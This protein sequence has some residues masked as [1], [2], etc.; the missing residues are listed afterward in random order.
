MLDYEVI[1]S[2]LEE[3]GEI[4]IKEYTKL[5]TTKDTYMVRI[6]I[7]INDRSGLIFPN[8]MTFD[9]N[10]TKKKEII[11]R[12]IFDDIKDELWHCINEYKYESCQ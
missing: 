2:L 4:V 1:K 3:A 11:F 6:I 10:E 5:E 12:K 7:E 9:K 8:I